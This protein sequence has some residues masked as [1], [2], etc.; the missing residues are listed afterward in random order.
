M[1]EIRLGLIGAGRWGRN[2]IPT[3]QGL[4]GVA[5]K[6]IA[7][8]NPETEKLAP[9]DC[10]VDG[11]WKTV[12]RAKDIDGVIVA[13]P[14]ATHANMV[15]VAVQAGLPVFVEKPLTLDVG[16][17]E[18]LGDLVT[19]FDGYVMVDHTQLF[20]PA[21]IAL[22]DAM[23]RLGPVSSIRSE[24]GNWGPFRKDATVLWDWGPH[25]V[26]MCLDLMCQAPS[27]VSARRVGVGGENGE[28]I[29]LTM[30][31]SN[32]VTATIEIGNIRNEKARRFDVLCRDGELSFDDL[33][34]K[35][36][37][38]NSTQKPSV[39][40]AKAME[41]STEMP[42]TR[43][44]RQFVEEVDGGRRGGESLRLGIEVVRILA[45]CQRALDGS[46]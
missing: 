31:F 19:D 17:A 25:D 23:D 9:A 22:K 46:P 41:Y 4:P 27:T 40:L 20:N 38:L 7:S 45:R 35:K 30:T 1:V 37:T 42:L 12:A 15:S 29:E 43:A 3:V 18:A 24:A 33:A 36:L 39:A 10:Q 21:F 8:S 44:V 13:T 32:D 6:R 28:N 14:P 5:L 34:A 2:F 11:D 26:A 16:E